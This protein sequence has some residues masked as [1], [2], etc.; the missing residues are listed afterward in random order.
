[1]H[2][3]SIP[4][5]I[6]CGGRGTRLRE[7]TGVIPKPLVSI[8][9]RPI[10]WHIMKTYYAHGF[11][12]FVLLLGYKGE[13]IKE[14][15]RDYA[16]HANS[17][18]FKN[19]KGGSRMTH[20]AHLEEA[21]EVTCLDTGLETQTGARLKQA[22]SVLKEKTFMLTYG[23][24]VADVDLD[25]LLQMHRAQGRLVT[26]TG[27]HQP[28]RFGELH[29]VDDQVASFNEKPAQSTSMING[30]FFVC[31]RRLLEKLSEESSLNFEQQI[32]P[33]LASEGQLAVHRHAGYWQ[34]MDTVRDMEILQAAWDSGKAPWK[35]W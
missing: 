23:D 30:G 27:V 17:V 10:L 9:G 32:L 25:A 22:A 12:R 18:T 21:W 31:N 34:C 33:L 5:V 3:R 20:H 35:I 19:T 1:M 26:V 7:E 11:R 24:G 2:P 15:F 29:L 6:F 16:L 8:G 4:V 13:K 14:Y 28:A